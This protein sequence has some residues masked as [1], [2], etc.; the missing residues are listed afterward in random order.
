MAVYPVPPSNED[1][2]LRAILALEQLPQKIDRAMQD[3]TDM[4]TALIKIDYRVGTVEQRL[5]RLEEGEERVGERSYADLKEELK[6]AKDAQQHW[7]RYIIA[8]LV[9]LFIGGLML[10]LGKLAGK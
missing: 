8:S 9:T 7:G 6:R 5:A 2:L 3:R 10:W 1:R 4:T